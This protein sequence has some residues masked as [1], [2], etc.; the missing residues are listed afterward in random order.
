M[1]AI[2]WG[3][4]GLD[5]TLDL[6]QRT[7]DRG[8]GWSEHSHEFYEVFWIEEGYCLHRLNGEARSSGKRRHGFSHSGGQA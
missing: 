6:F 7:H 5:I 3:W 2:K 4:H 8:K 1:G